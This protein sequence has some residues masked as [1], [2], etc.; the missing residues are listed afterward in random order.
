MND[1]ISLLLLFQKIKGLFLKQKNECISTA[2]KKVEKKHDISEEEMIYNKTFIDTY[3]KLVE[4]W[5]ITYISNMSQ[6][7]KDN[8]KTL[9]KNNDILCKKHINN[10]D[11]INILK[12]ELLKL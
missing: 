1:S 4:S 11:L 3:N 7:D 10:I 6:S 8:L 5:C 12:D 9:L 2:I